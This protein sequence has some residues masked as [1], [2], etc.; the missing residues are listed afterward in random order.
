M[1]DL[2]TMTLVQGGLTAWLLAKKRKDRCV[3]LHSL[4]PSFRAPS[5]AVCGLLSCACI[6]FDSL[7]RDWA[8]DPVSIC[9]KSLYRRSLPSAPPPSSCQ[10]HTAIALLFL[11]VD[12]RFVISLSVECCML[13]VKCCL[14]FVVISV[15]NVCLTMNIQWD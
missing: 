11:V 8:P 12:V 9:N 5:S 3:A 15:Y 1:D 2:G 6:L 10:E 14:L 7:R 4:R 13:Y